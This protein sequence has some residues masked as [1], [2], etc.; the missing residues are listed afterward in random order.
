MINRLNHFANQIP[1]SLNAIHSYS[2]RIV[3]EEIPQPKEFVLIGI[4][5]KLTNI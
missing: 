5:S 4:M 1:I 3:N 2:Y